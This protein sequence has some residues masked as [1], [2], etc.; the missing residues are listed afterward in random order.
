MAKHEQMKLELFY[1]IIVRNGFCYGKNKVELN[2]MPFALC[3]NNS[4]GPCAVVR[5]AQFSI[6]ARF[7]K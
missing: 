6:D 5:F 7:S 1:V 4:S 2:E 3:F